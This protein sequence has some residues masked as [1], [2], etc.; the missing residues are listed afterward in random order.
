MLII[1]V[2]AL[3]LSVVVVVVVV[4]VLEQAKP[5][6]VDKVDKRSVFGMTIGACVHNVAHI[7]YQRFLRH[8][9]YVCAP[10]H[11][12]PRTNTTRSVVHTCANEHGCVF[13]CVRVCVCVQ[14]AW[15]T[16][17]F[18]LSSSVDTSRRTGH[19]LDVDVCMLFA[20]GGSGCCRGRGG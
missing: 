2:V 8:L 15:C 20:I 9:V 19:N 10:I 5:V 6:G 7:R 16:W 11:T 13:V 18:D 1:L 12:T 3:L 14:A 4:V 17:Q